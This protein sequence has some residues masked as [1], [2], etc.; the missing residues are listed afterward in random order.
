MNNREEIQ[1]AYTVIMSMDISAEKKSELINLV[2]ETVR[3]DCSIR[4]SYESSKEA[5]SRL[6]FAQKLQTKNIKEA[7][8][9]ITVIK[10]CLMVIKALITKREDIDA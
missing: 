1:E 10:R 4:R 3:R 9:K 2:N 5:L 8:S 6:V 7:S